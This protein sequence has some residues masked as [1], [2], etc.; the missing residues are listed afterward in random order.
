MPFV[1]TYRCS[2]IHESG[3]DLLVGV[4]TLVHVHGEVHHAGVGEQVQLALLQVRLIVV[5]L[6]LGLHS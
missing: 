1:C 2:L 4:E 5:L 3:R 6:H